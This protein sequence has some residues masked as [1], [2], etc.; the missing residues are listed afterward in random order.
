[1]TA[2]RSSR[3]HQHFDDLRR[4]HRYG[5]NF[6]DVLAARSVSRQLRQGEIGLGQ[7]RA[8]VVPEVMRN[9]GSHQAEALKLLR[10]E[11]SVVGLLEIGYI[12]ARSDIAGE[13]AIRGGS[14]YA[15]IEHPTIFSIV[16]SQPVFDLKAPAGVE[17]RAV[18][19]TA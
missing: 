11:Q 9:S 12:G 3:G 16:P 19:C 10:G 13:E 14:W 7:N 18:G 2:A 15:T 17:R 4:P 6:L 1:G 8:E 5:R